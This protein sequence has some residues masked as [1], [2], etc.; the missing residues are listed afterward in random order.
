MVCAPG[1]NA[2]SCTSFLESSVGK[3]NS[4][5]VGS[6][7]NDCFEKI[8]AGQADLVMVGGDELFRSNTVYGFQPAISQVQ[9][10]ETGVSYYSVAIVPKGS[11]LCNSKAKNFAGLKVNFR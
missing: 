5:V 7:A 1:G 2:E 4:C 9:S 11:D 8:K 3:G 6:S 10:A